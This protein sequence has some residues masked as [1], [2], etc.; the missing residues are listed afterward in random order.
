MYLLIGLALLSLM[1]GVWRLT[2]HSNDFGDTAWW[3]AL[4]LLA[5]PTSAG[6]WIVLG[7]L[8][9]TTPLARIA[10]VGLLERA[11][12]ETRPGYAEGMRMTSAF[13]P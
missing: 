4:F 10:G 3:W 8:A 1:T 7:P 11:L 9:M 13:A 6:F 12:K 5:A 2:R